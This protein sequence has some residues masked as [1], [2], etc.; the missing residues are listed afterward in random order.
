MKKT[1]PPAI[2]LTDV[3]AAKKFSEKD[4]VVLIAFFED[5]E[6]KGALAFKAVADI[7][8]SLAFGTTSSK[9][10]AEALGCSLDSIV[11]FKQV[12][13]SLVCVRCY[14]IRTDSFYFA[15]KVCIHLPPLPHSLMTVR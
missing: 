10:V 5:L 11:L 14:L 12:S 3:E 8:D 2:E 4:E 7:Q 13:H 15:P 6:S 1:G 9:E